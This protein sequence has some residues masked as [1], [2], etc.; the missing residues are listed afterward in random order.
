M[1]EAGDCIASPNPEPGP[2]AAPEAVAEAD[3]SV[4]PA[5]AEGGGCGGGEAPGGWLV[6]AGLMVA[7]R[8]RTMRVRG[9]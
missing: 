8:A 1:C 4:N 2:E 7:L 5:K 6:L 3:D 9:R